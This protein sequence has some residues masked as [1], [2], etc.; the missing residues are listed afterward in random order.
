MLAPQ[1]QAI[2]TTSPLDAAGRIAAAAVLG[3]EGVQVAQQAHGQRESA[4]L[5]VTPLS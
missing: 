5:T 4:T 3:E 1:S 2:Q